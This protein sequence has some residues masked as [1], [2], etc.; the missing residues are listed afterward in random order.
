MIQKLEFIHF[1]SINSIDT[2]GDSFDST[3]N[4]IQKYKNR[5]KIYL[6]NAE[7]PIGFSNIRAQNNS[8]VFS[9]ILNGITYNITIASGVY[10]TISSLL[11]VLNAAILS[12]ITALG[13]T[14][15][16]SALTTNK[17][18][19]TS[20]GGFSTYS[21]ITNTLSSILNITSAINQVAGTYTS[22]Y[23]YNLGYDTYIQICFYNIPSIFSSQGNVPSALKIPLNT[24][25][26]NILFYN[27]D[28]NDYDQSLTISDTNFILSQMR[29]IMYDRYGFPL[30]NGSLDYSFTIAI[31]YYLDV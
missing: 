1:D 19:I 31:E 23:I 2:N 17:I 5:N 16:L 10:S 22:P 6:K 20:T 15:V 29:I 27:T 9:F 7:I 4:V 24:N 18:I 21:I 3:F 25:A 26:Y 30:N 13:F 28:R 12:A 8:N 14:F 11:T